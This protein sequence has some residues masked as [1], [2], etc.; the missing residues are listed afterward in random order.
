[1][2]VDTAES[3]FGFQPF[4]SPHPMDAYS[5]N[6]PSE[7][8]SVDSFMATCPPTMEATPSLPTSSEG[9]DTVTDPNL[10]AFPAIGIAQSPLDPSIS[11][12]AYESLDESLAMLLNSDSPVL[13]L[14]DIVDLGPPPMPVPA[15]DEDLPRTKQSAYAPSANDL[16]ISAADARRR[17]IHASSLD[18]FVHSHAKATCGR[19]RRGRANGLLQMRS[20]R[21]S[22]LARG[23]SPMFPEQST[24]LSVVNGHQSST[25]TSSIALTT[26]SSDPFGT[27]S[28]RH[29][30]GA[31]SDPGV[32][33]VHNN[34]SET[35]PSVP[36]SPVLSSHSDSPRPA[37][38]CHGD[39]SPKFTFG[40]VQPS[41]VLETSTRSNMEIDT[42]AKHARRIMELDKRILK[43]QAE[44][45]R[46]LSEK[47]PKDASS[48]ERSERWSLT[49]RPMEKGKVNLYVM[50]LNIY[51]LD[52][53]FYEEAHTLIR[54]IGGLHY[55]LTTALTDLRGICCK[56]MFIV[57]DMSTC[58]AFIKSFLHENQQ[59][60]LMSSIRG[61]YTIQLATESCRSEGHSE[62]E[63]ALASANNVLRCAQH[64]TLAFTNID[65]RLK[66]VQEMGREKM[67]SCD[68]ICQSLGI[69][70]RERRTY[71]RSVVEGNNATVA[72]AV[73]TWTQYYINATNTIKSITE[74]I[75]PTPANCIK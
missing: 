63:Q 5:P 9:Y 1:M 72:S 39:N 14:K 49:E 48:D 3:F 35:L 70:D 73:K 16:P 30:A 58:F 47:M 10:S 17:T 2:E 20:L 12:A 18:S 37:V 60:K 68:A 42:A 15:I 57:P 8:G 69:V 32:Y 67:R 64:I 53:P 36:A 40:S 21:H 74:C 54:Q 33:A 43:L 61:I 19:D 11:G 59:L 71:I 29:S 56:G 66:R 41:Q 62:F 22:K 13:E 24:P 26:S 44:R 38:S 27:I 7:G 25:S 6:P 50:A 34:H 46:Y 28:S 45:A 4:S 52:E 51:A 55:D 65:E 31:V 23:S 75:H